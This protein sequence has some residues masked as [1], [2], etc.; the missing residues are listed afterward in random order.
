MARTE[1]PKPTSSMIS[2][3]R[4]AQVPKSQPSDSLSWCMLAADGN[5]GSGCGCLNSVIRHQ[6][7]STTTITVVIFMICMARS[8][9]S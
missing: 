2:G 3:I 1:W 7:M 4:A 6:T 8:L 5:G 9:D